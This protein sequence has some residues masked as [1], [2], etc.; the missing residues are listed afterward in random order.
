MRII[1]AIR[2]LFSEIPVVTAWSAYPDEPGYE[3]ARAGIQQLC[4]SGELRFVEKS[5]YGRIFQNDEFTVTLWEVDGWINVSTRR[6][7]G[8]PAARVRL[9]PAWR[10]MC[11][12][13]QS[14]PLGSRYSSA[15][16]VGP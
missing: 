6:L 16:T 9:K 12:I 15:P 10:R 13:T 2:K 11:K 8:W 3:Q 4:D 14:V 7:Q 1:E 5:R